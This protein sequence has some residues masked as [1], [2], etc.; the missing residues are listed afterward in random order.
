MSSFR[1]FNRQ[2]GRL[3]VIVAMLVATV[4]PALTPA[5]VSAEGTVTNRSVAL[6]TSV[7]ATASTE[8]E[9]AFHAQTASTGAFIVDFCDSAPIGATCNT[10]AGLD[11]T[12][13]T[14]PTSGYTVS[15]TDTNTVKV[16]IGTPVG[17]DGAVD[18]KITGLRTPDAAG[19]IYA[20]ILTYTDS[21]A[22]GSHDSETAT[23][24][25]PLDS[26]AVALTITDGFSVNGKVLESL[27]FCAS[28]PVSDA[29]PITSGCG[30][31]LVTPNVSLGT[32]G[33][34]STTLSEGTIYTQLST[35][36]AHGA[37]VSLKNSAA[38]GGLKRT[39]AT[40][41]DITPITAHGTIGLG[42]AK[43]GLKLGNLGA[44][45]GTIAPV[46][47]YSDADYYM[48]YA[49]NGSSGV[50]SAYGDPIYNSN[51]NPVNNGSVDLTFGANISNVTPAGNYSAAL[52]LIATGTF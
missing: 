5:F 42:D 50:T 36:A 13:P 6:G 16:V 49:S 43:F 18:V 37:V 28:A 14:T 2:A 29:N 41:S 22:A 12:T 35:N 20:R 38:G 48:G 39:E 9:V 1:L 7:K 51:G 8:Y 52:N 3:S 31:P 10:P 40:T 33:V 4:L 17:V 32:D 30:G 11:V 24:G 45:T 26:G 25:S 46:G 23:M 47:D 15:A 21:T 19:A 34:L 44:G 27:V